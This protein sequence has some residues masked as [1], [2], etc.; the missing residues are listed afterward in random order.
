ML[1]ITIKNWEEY[2][3]YLGVK[4]VPELAEA[5]IQPL[6]ELIIQKKWFHY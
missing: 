4:T 6:R 1:E 3:D 5:L 2:K